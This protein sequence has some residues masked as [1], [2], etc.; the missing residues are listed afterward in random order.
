MSWPSSSSFFGRD[1]ALVYENSSATG[2]NTQINPSNNDFEIGVLHAS[3]VEPER[4]A[5]LPRQVSYPSGRIAVNQGANDSRDDVS[6]SAEREFLNNQS[7]YDGVSHFERTERSGA[8][9]ELPQKHVDVL[10]DGVYLI[11][12]SRDSFIGVSLSPPAYLTSST[13][14]CRSVQLDGPPS[15]QDSWSSGLKPPSRKHNSSLRFHGSSILNHDARLLSQPSNLE[16]QAYKPAQKMRLGGLKALTATRPSTAHSPKAA[17]RVTKS[18]SKTSVRTYSSL[19]GSEDKSPTHDFAVTIV[20][21]ES[22]GESTDY[23]EPTNDKGAFIPSS[24]HS[25]AARAANVIRDWKIES[26]SEEQQRLNWEAYAKYE[27]ETGP[28]CHRAA[29][30][31]DLLL[32]D[33][34]REIQNQLRSK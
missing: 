21:R 25:I 13:R 30:R 20:E 33:C 7:L 14:S 34:Q 15:Q 32:R 1:T 3:T 24:K 8:Q 9:D 23:G 16:R 10:L 18:P 31:K 29:W 2:Q 17:G 5:L 26:N 22:S 28:A 4:L 6:T 12:A 27:L 19:R 11:T